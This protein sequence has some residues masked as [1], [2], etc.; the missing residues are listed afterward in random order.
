MKKN[1]KGSSLITVIIIMAVVFITGTAILS[2]LNVNYRIRVKENRRLQNLYASE[3]GVD[4]AYNIIAKTFEVAIDKAYTEV[5]NLE[6][7][8]ELSEE[9]KD[10]MF[11]MN[12]KNFI[13]NNKYINSSG[14]KN[15]MYDLFKD[16]VE[17]LKYVSIGLDGDINYSDVEFDFYEGKSKIQEPLLS[18]LDTSKLNDE[19]NEYE[20][21]LS[22][23]FY[24][25][26]STGENKRIIE[27]TYDIK[28][29]NFEDITLNITDKESVKQEFKSKA[30]ITDKNIVFNNGATINGDIFALGSNKAENLETKY[31]G[32]IKFIN[33][34]DL[35]SNLINVNGN[36][37][38]LNTFSLVQNAKVN[39]N[40]SLYAGNVYIGDGESKVFEGKNNNLYIGNNSS[41]NIDDLDS[42]VVLNNDLVI[43]SINSNI[44]IDNF[45]GI[46]DIT[47]NENG[48]E[49]KNS[50]SII[51]NN[52]SEESTDYSNLT[53]KNNAYIMGSAYINAK[54][55]KGK[56]YQT[57]E[58]TA[59]NG[60][61]I[62]YTVPLEGNDFESIEFEYYDTLQLVE[63]YKNDK[64]S[65]LTVSDKSEYF[66][67]FA[68]ENKDLLNHGG[69]NFLNKENVKAIGSVIYKNE[70]DSV[71][72]L[73]SRYIISNDSVIK[74]K[75][76]KY[77]KYVYNMG[78]E[79]TN[80]ED[81][82]KKVSDYLISLK[83]Y[84]PVQKIN[85]DEVAIISDDKEITITTEN[86]I[87]KITVG[88]ETI[89]FDDNEIKAV[90]VTNSE[91]NID[92]NVNFTGTIISTE[93]VSVKNG[94]FEYSSISYDE[95]TVQRIIANNY[96]AFKNLG[97]LSG[98]NSNSTSLVSE[99]KYQ[100]DIKRYIKSKNWKIEK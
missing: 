52:N 100:Y 96:S 6:D 12:F 16:T 81:S 25:N 3:A 15:H 76:N 89:T 29:P 67:R 30:I 83:E 47:I 45:Y 79:V 13:S 21:D 8:N 64:G 93:D 60:N 48:K 55:S 7:F 54:N 98:K 43:N 27:L 74:N 85:L 82:P 99:N 37:Y 49:V 41:N 87:G 94:T 56:Y 91:V 68:A 14:E 61:Y 28:I 88:N 1:N 5:K 11:K 2:L 59:V 20:L 32:G 72:V 44:T 46:N 78:T 40:G 23:E 22:S 34:Q 31:N 39:I 51:V 70:D 42:E 35:E 57:G 95:K 18:I 69:I 50:S 63:K 58:S 73:E 65:N 19:N 33:N 9:E 66:D 4:T 24:T 10:K 92:G 97:I 86:N 71:G 90:I 36:M 75:K 26:D 53:I 77:I 38:T 84:I 17:G 80:D 62:A